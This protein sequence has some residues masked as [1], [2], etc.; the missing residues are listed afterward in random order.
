MRI[1]LVIRELNDKELGRQ[2]KV[3]SAHKNI[4]KANDAKQSWVAFFVNRSKV[5][6][7]LNTSVRLYVEGID[8]EGG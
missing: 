5:L 3:L 7:V 8:L 4:N 6:D 1:Y 2:T